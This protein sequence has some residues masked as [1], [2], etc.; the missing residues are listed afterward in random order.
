MIRDVLLLVVAGVWTVVMVLTA[1]RTGQIPAE[2]WAILPAGVGAILTAFR[3]D[4]SFRAR[5]RAD[6][7]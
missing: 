4:A 3:V 1:W 7:K 6:D 2:L 5:D